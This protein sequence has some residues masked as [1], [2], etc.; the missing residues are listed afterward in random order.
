METGLGVRVTLDMACDILNKGIHIYCDNFFACPEL[1]ARLGTKKTYCIGTVR[2]IRLGFT[3]FNPTQIKGLKRG[4]DISNVESF[5]IKP[6]S[7]NNHR[8][9]SEADSRANDDVVDQPI[10]SGSTDEA[11]SLHS[12]SAIVVDRSGSDTGP[13]GNSTFYPVHCFCWKDKKEVFFVNTVTDLREVTEVRRKKPDGSAV[14]YP[15]PLSVHLYNKYMG[16]VD[17]ADAMR[18]DYSTSRKSKYKWYMRLFWFLLDTC[19]VNA[20]ILECES[21]NHKP[22]LGRKHQPQLDFV[23]ELDQ[24]LV[25]EHSSR[26]T[27]GRPTFIPPSESRY[28]PHVPVEYNNPHFALLKQLGSGLS[29]DKS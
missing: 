11:D 20:Y 25:E 4:E 28:N 5:E 6:P 13:S 26:K 8:H 12:S 14:R 15:C 21:P 9:H 7:S 29:M 10:S 27:L 22:P 18:R 23:V 1:A 17:L 2:S 16:G 24:Q 19:I 3:K